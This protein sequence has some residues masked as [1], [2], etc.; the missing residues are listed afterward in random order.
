MLKT[1]HTPGN[2]AAPFGVG[3]NGE[4]GFSPEEIPSGHAVS[5]PADY[6]VGDGGTVPALGE[7][8]LSFMVRFSVNRL[9]R[10]VAIALVLSLSVSLCGFAGECEEIRGRVL[11][12]HVLAN[13]NSEEDQALK[14]K[15]RDTV[16]E[17]AAGLFDTA[18]DEG[19][20]LAQARERLPE[21]EAAAQQRVYDEGY[22]YE[23]H[24][25]LCE[26]YFTT[27]QYETVTLPA[28]LY[29]A[30]RITIGTGEGKNWWCVV[31][32]PMCVS[33]ATQA[34][35]LSDVLEP[36]QEEIVTQPKKYEVR[37]KVVELFEGVRRQ[38]NDWFG[39][40]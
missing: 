13:S 34:A 25:Q 39:E 22:A 18:T 9:V 3:Q 40:K 17:K 28:G 1:A 8:V 21:I 26:M 19:E 36:E 24:A 4:G 30:L 27:R 33:A 37:F 23:V 20:A 16:V 11:R 7:R 14:L 15:V 6:G 38:L 32:P 31:F 2:E 29:D 12:L 10:A 35:E 5:C